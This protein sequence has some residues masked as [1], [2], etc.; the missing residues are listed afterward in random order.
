MVAA[1]TGAPIPE[2]TT[3]AAA[4]WLA[5]LCGLEAAHLGPKHPARDPALH[6][7][8]ALARRCRIVTLE[9]AGSAEGLP[10]FTRDDIRPW[11]GAPWIEALGEFQAACLEGR[12]RALI[13]P[14]HRAPARVLGELVL[15]ALQIVVA[16]RD[17]ALCFF[18]LAGR[19]PQGVYYP[20][21]DLFLVLSPFPL[22]HRAALT[23]MLGFL[24]PRPLPLARWLARALR[25]ALRPA[26]VVG[27]MRPGH[28]LKES[29]A[30]LDAREAALLGFLDRGGLLV[31]IADWCAMDPLAVLPS[32]RRGDAL[33]LRSARAAERCLDLGLDAHRVFRTKSHPDAGWLRRRLGVAAPASDPSRF[34][35][36][37]SVDA[38]RGRVLNQVEAFR[39]VLRRLRAA[40]RAR[41]MALD[42]VWDGWT[43]PHLPGERDLAVMAKIEAAIATITADPEAAPDTE[44]RIFGRSFAAKVP[45]IAGCDLAIATQGTAALLPSWLLERPTIVYHVASQI[46]NRSDLAE[47]SVIQ[48]D[49]RAVI[50]ERP[51]AAAA[52]GLRFSLALWG[53]EDALVRAVGERLGL[54]RELADHTTMKAGTA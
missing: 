33:L 6:G 16:L 34:R 8:H 37:L 47:H 4:G 24:L 50:E 31:L 12:E 48:L 30:Y 9:A 40:C 26:F 17:G 25:G 7:P 21:R 38:E 52:H 27:D 22:D 43:V 20:A 41:G 18:L 11:R 45:D 10:R 13:S 15:E 46:P 2:L 3:E 35:V 14:L 42:V 5:A 49:Q 53:V 36:L 32:L 28:F 23:R 51:D 29:L 54:V 44:T 1:D 19:I 39:F